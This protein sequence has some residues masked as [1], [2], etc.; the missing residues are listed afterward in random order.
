MLIFKRPLESI[1]NYSRVLKLTNYSEVS[2]VQV[3]SMTL[4]AGI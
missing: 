2:L 1:Q 4:L 3:W